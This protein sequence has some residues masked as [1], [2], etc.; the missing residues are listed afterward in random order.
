M[1]KIERKS[2]VVVITGLLMLVVLTLST[3]IGSATAEAPAVP[4]VD[5]GDA[6]N[7]PVWDN[8][9]YHH[10]PTTVANLAGTFNVAHEGLYLPADPAL[11]ITPHQNKDGIATVEQY[12]SL[13]SVVLDHGDTKLN[14]VG[15]T[16]GD[17]IMFWQ[18]G[19]YGSAVG[20]V[21][22]GGDKLVLHSNLQVVDS[23]NNPQGL[24][25]GSY[26]LQRVPDID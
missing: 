8:F 11:S 23:D 24:C 13:L 6:F 2:A 10:L 4:F 15:S 26:V 1:N 14:L 17:N 19:Y 20:T 12:G 25:I 21:L 16:A 22:D 18:P 9:D 3:G 5:L 7:A